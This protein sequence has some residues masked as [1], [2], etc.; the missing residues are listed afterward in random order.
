MLRGVWGIARGEGGW[1]RSQGGNEQE[2]EKILDQELG[3][4]VGYPSQS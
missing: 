3:G 1:R 2:L 4:G